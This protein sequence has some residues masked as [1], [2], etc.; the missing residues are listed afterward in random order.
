MRRIWTVVVVVAALVSLSTAFANASAGTPKLRLHKTKVGTILV[1]NH[2][3]TVYA[4]TKDRRGKDVC[5]KIL[6]C[7]TAWPPVTAGGLIAG[8]GVKASLVGRIKLKDGTTQL[9]YAGHALYT[10]AG[11]SEP[12]E[13]DNV[14]LLQ[15]GGRWPALNAAGKE[16]K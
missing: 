8:R 1:D 14:N 11:D 10:Y 3:F 15:F 5:I 6:A 2:G 7:L 16:L 9:T 12:G 13:T 4:F